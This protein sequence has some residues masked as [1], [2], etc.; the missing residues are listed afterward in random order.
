MTRRRGEK[1][2]KSRRK[3]NSKKESEMAEQV[4]RPNLDRLDIGAIEGL[5]RRNNDTLKTSI[6]EE[7]K[8]ALAPV[9]AESAEL[10]KRIN[11]LED[12]RKSDELG[13][14]M[15]TPSAAAAAELRKAAKLR[16]QAQEAEARAALAAE[17][18][19]FI[20]NAPRT[21]AVVA[22]SNKRT[23][24][25]AMATLSNPNISV[26]EEERA[27]RSL[28]LAQTGASSPLLR[29]GVLNSGPSISIPL[30][31]EDGCST[32][33]V[34]SC[35]LGTVAGGAVGFFMAGPIG[36][37]VGATVGGGSGIAMGHAACNASS[38]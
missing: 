23:Y 7:I 1:P 19:E 22:R 5:L 30:S 31:P 37:F 10:G 18:A 4:E 15:R 14:S 34:T 13:A 20:A 3:S 28:A 2:V 9:V 21:A 35:F 11:Q 27:L 36:L 33:K 38:I 8:V 26:E 25:R 32:T 16:E 29:G 6:S 17:R 12:L 24:E